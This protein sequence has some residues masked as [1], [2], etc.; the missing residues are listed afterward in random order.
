[1]DPSLIPVKS[2]T[3]KKLLASSAPPLSEIEK[4]VLEAADGHSTCLALSRIPGSG[5]T[6]LDSLFEKGLLKDNPLGMRGDVAEDRS[7]SAESDRVADP[8]AKIRAEA[9][10]RSNREALERRNA[11]SLKEAD[12]TVRREEVASVWTEAEDRAKRES[13][14]RRRLEAE[15]FRAREEARVEAERRIAAEAEL[16]EAARREAE[17]I[18]AEEAS[19]KAAEEREK[20]EK[21]SAES[22]KRARETRLGI[23]KKRR[24]RIA[25]ALF[26]AIGTLFA[27]FA[28]REFPVDAGECSEAASQWIGTKVS[29]SSCG[30]LF[31]PSPAIVATG[32]S[33]PDGS[34]E[35]REA[36]FFLSALSIPKGTHDIIGGEIS[37][38]KAIGD[39]FLTIANSNRLPKNA[40]ISNIA[41][42][43]AIV[44]VADISPGPLSG[45][46][47]FVDGRIDAIRLQNKEATRFFTVKTNP[48]VASFSF[49]DKGKVDTG[50][51]LGTVES[52]FVSGTLKK[53]SI[54]VEAFSFK[55]S[56][57]EAKGK[58][59]YRMAGQR[60]ELD[61]VFESSRMDAEKVF[62]WLFFDGKMTV[63]GAVSSRGDT[64]VGI[65]KNAS[66]SGRLS[67]DA[68]TFKSVDFANALGVGRSSAGGTKFNKL[69][70]NFSFSGSKTSLSSL[71]A[72]SNP[73]DI[74]I[75][76]I[77]RTPSEVTGLAAASAK[78]GSETL[79]G[80][81]RI[82]G[83]D[84]EIRLFTK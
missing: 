7:G 68:G 74:K 55:A 32:I 83:N 17:R 79:S 9:R 72:E 36:K 35:I 80:N 70:S 65:A 38:L 37:D 5:E 53:D 73:Y 33:T 82:E 66:L 19:A 43:G 61:G 24:R 3:A 57:G 10:E 52:P 75:G 13:E 40:S 12:R 71:E 84:T 16:Q 18:A 21:E 51:A 46:I 58:A 62:P 20:K 76:S 27:S 22:E 31:F 11:K 63:S 14:E 42:N 34:L 54:E 67:V 8:M 50:S 15:L 64:V 44:Y 1:M 41:V 25:I 45:S 39:S 4:S 69:S 30:A 23:T 47:A 2:S 48:G 78:I 29:V 59:S 60:Y 56:F 81:F 77:E 26:G 49:E 6:L 28:Y